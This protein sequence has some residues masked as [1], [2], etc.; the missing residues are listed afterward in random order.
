MTAFRRWRRVIVLAALASAW[1]GVSAIAQPGDASSRQAASLAAVEAR[2]PVG[3]VVYVTDASGA[4][5]KGA[6]A[7]VTGDVM[8]V[9]IRTDVR[10]MAAA[11]IRRVQWQR[12]DSLLNGVLIGAAIGAAPGIYF[13][14]TD[15]NE[16]T[17]LCPEEWAAVGI[18]AAVGGLVDRAV[19][20][21]TTV[22]EAPPGDRSRSVAIAPLVTPSR[23]G[24]RLIVRF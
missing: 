1:P 20:Q 15:P 13:L 23:R 16:C 18:S 19:R 22:Y 9:R 11:D 10:E 4:T 12:R 5:I 17:G 24:V 3:D 7:S 6:L 21:R 8:R 14:I 2:V